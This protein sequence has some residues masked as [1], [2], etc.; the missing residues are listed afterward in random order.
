MANH[1]KDESVVRH[2]GIDCK[3][4]YTNNNSEDEIKLKLVADRY[5]F[6]YNRSREEDD[7]Y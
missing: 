1:F 7:T 4:K 2:S 3:S 6:V 5:W